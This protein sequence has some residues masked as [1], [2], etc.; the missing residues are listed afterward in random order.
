MQLKTLYWG[1]S[2]SLALFV[3]VIFLAQIAS[4]WISQYP[5]LTAIYLGTA[6]LSLFGCAYF[7]PRPVRVYVQSQ[8]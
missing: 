4:D 1:A 7:F 8:K 3:G 5:V 6:A 2:A